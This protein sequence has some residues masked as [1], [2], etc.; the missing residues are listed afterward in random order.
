MGE[1]AR[2][3]TVSREAFRYCESVLYQ[4]HLNKT[5]LGD[6]RDS[7]VDGRA[8]GA[9]DSEG[10]VIMGTG[11]GSPGYSDQVLSRVVRLVSDREL[12]R[13]ERLT[14]AVERMYALVTPDHRDVIHVKYWGGH[15]LVHKDLGHEG[16]WRLRNCDLADLI[17]LSLSTFDRRRREVIDM[18]ALLLDV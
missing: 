1:A 14:A 18:L 10:K 5:K 12:G 4:Y 13:L 3:E 16:V 2:E 11:A 9:R 17:R 7:M 8:G 6:L 15:D